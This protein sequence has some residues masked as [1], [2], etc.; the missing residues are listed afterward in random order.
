MK[1]SIH[2]YSCIV[3]MLI[4]LFIG[5]SLHSQDTSITIKYDTTVIN[6]SKTIRI[7]TVRTLPKFILHFNAGYNSGAMELTS[8]NGGY[9]RNDFSE[10]KNYSARHGFGFNLIGKLPLGKKGNFWLDVIAGFDRFQSDIFAKNTEEGKV[11]YNSFNGGIGI[12][13]NFTPTH[14]VKYY[15]GANPLISLISGKSELINPDNNRVDIKIKNS[16]R[17]GYQAFFGLEYA[18]D[19][20]FGLNAGLRFTH[21]NLLLKKSEEP[22]EDPNASPPSTTVG[23]NDNATFDPIQFAGWKQFA[24][25]SA[26]VGISY[27]FGVKEQ[28]YKLP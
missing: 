16:L 3:I 20:N 26:S 25:F 15:F 1:R 22:V 9:S 10:G 13:Y 21:A 27:F 6:K 24:Y 2:K 14:K 11:Y 4:A 8:H 23:L 5:S 7:V 17:I 12:E 18:F 19:K 28:R